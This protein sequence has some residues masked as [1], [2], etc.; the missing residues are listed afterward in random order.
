VVSQ[1]KHASQAY[2]AH[3]EGLATVEALKQGLIVKATKLSQIQ[4]TLFDRRVNADEMER[5]RLDQDIR[6]VEGEL[7][8]LS[9]YTKAAETLDNDNTARTPGQNDQAEIDQEWLDK[10]DEYAR[11]HNEPWR[12]TLLARALANESKA[13]S[14]IGP[15]GLWF[16]GTVEKQLFDAF[17]VILD[18]STMMGGGLIIPHPQNFFERTIPGIDKDLAIANLVFQLGELNV[19]GDPMTSM[20]SFPPNTAFV[21]DYGEKR[22]V[23]HTNQKLTVQGIVPTKLGQAIAILYD[24]KSNSLGSE[25]FE[26]WV[27]TIGEPTAKLWKSWETT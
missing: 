27:A 25:I 11:R 12:R 18:L 20:K 8:K 3:Q 14:S 10:F 17:S 7:R 2:I 15:R 26:A 24:R 22:A 5:V 9:I 16:I 1:S 23:I 19:I 13:P 6:Y 4:A 21:A